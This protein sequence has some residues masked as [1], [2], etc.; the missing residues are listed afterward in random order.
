MLYYYV[1][2]VINSFS[3]FSV[4]FP[5]ISRACFLFLPRVGCGATWFLML[6]LIAT[7]HKHVMR[8]CPRSWFTATSGPDL[9]QWMCQVPCSFTLQAASL[10]FYQTLAGLGKC[11]P[12]LWVH[13]VPDEGSWLSGWN[14]FEYNPS[15]SPV[16]GMV[17]NAHNCTVG[18]VCSPSSWSLPLGITI[19]GGFATPVQPTHLFWCFLQLR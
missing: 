13:T 16:P 7:G 14:R 12:S 18:V 8:T 11:S 4:S 9:T 6:E 1:F 15:L 2:Y 5:V 17:S 19:N 10:G 3:T